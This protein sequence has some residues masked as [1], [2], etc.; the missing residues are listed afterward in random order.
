MKIHHVTRTWSRPFF[1]A[2]K[3]HHCPVCGTK[4][5][6]ASV[7]KIVHSKSDEAKDYDFSSPGGDGYMMGNVKFI[8]T[9]FHCPKC[10]QNFSIDEIYR[11]EKAAKKSGR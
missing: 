6:K 10:D 11:S 8:R 3:A 1:V 9:V 7:S 2:F 4:L 5:E